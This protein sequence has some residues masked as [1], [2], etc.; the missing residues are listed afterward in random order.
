MAVLTSEPD[1]I[2]YVTDDRPGI[3]RR[4]I[5]RGFRYLEANGEAA[6]SQAIQERIRALAIPPAWSDVWICPLSNGHL[7]VTGRDEKGRKQY[8]YHPKWIEYR[9]VTKFN[10]LSEFANSLS[11]LRERMDKDLRRP[12]VPRQKA[13]AAA[14]WLL[15]RTLIRIGN[16]SYTAN[17]SYGI[18]TLT[19]DHVVAGAADLKFRFQGKAARQWT[20]K[21]SDRRI[22]NVIRKIQD[23]PGQ[24][25]LQYVDADGETHPISS[26]D[27]NSYIGETIGRGFSS[28]FFR[29]WG[30]TT[31]AA[32]LLSAT[33]LPAAARLVRKS[34]NV[35]ID[36]VAT[37]L[38]NTRAVCRQS[39]IHP[40][41]IEHWE[42]GKLTQELTEVTRRARN[43]P[44]HL[45]SLE[46]GVRIW[47][48]EYGRLEHR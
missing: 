20:V 1:N 22:A 10:E 28:K 33:P 8:I 18:T 42:A 35:A 39:Y 48:E 26:N 12:L 45:S 2:V 41:V 3:R 36:R 40:A 17:G 46:Q 19:S 4:R 16:E 14:V 30:G 15:D 32:E 44:A 24:R 9:D 21:I 29:T 43:R 6:T 37:E 7:Q 34:L 25:L 27:V 47:L 31:R 11:V 38:R 5:G 23:L 13:I